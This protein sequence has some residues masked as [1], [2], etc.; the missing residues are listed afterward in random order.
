MN[1]SEF[2]LQHDPR[3]KNR[4]RREGSV[5]MIFGVS[6]NSTTTRLRPPLKW[7]GGKRWLVPHLLP[8]WNPHS[9]RRLVEPFCG[10][11]AVALGLLPRKALLN[12]R[13]PHLIHFYCWLKRGLLV[14]DED[15]SSKDPKDI[16][17]LRMD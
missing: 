11:L 16:A 1:Q 3:L 6:L 12:D 2:G 7:A 5:W 13:N 17:G 8:Y 10:G 14:K 9:S 4:L 15:V